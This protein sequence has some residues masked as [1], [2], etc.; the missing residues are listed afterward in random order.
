MHLSS[1]AYDI[2]VKALL[3]LHKSF[4][5]TTFLTCL[6]LPRLVEEL[7]L[8]VRL[9]LAHGELPVREH[10][11]QSDSGRICLLHRS[12]HRLALLLLVAT[13][14]FLLLLVGV[15]TSHRRLVVVLIV[16]VVLFSRHRLF[17][18]DLRL[19]ELGLQRLCRLRH[20]SPHFGWCG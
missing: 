4:A 12:L 8:I 2:V 16:L 15:T 19:L 10:F 14:L 9:D 11:R 1:A 20:A 18:R 13:L 7:G 6:T 17:L 3:L 5:L